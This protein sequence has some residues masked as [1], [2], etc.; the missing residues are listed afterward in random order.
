MNF[1]NQAICH[2]EEFAGNALQA[3]NIKVVTMNGIAHTCRFATGRFF[4]DKSSIIKSWFLLLKVFVESWLKLNW[5]LWK[6]SYES[7]AREPGK[8]MERSL[9]PE[10]FTRWIAAIT[11]KL[12]SLT[13]CIFYKEDEKDAGSSLED[14]IGDC[15]QY[16]GIWNPELQPNRLLCIVPKMIATSSGE[17][18]KLKEGSFCVNGANLFNSLRKTLKNLEDVDLA[19][20]K[21][22][23]IS[24][25]FY[26]KLQANPIALGTVLVVELHQTAYYTWFL[27]VNLDYNL[28]MDM[29]NPI[30][31]RLYKNLSN[32]GAGHMACKPLNVSW[33]GF[34]ERRQMSRRLNHASRRPEHLLGAP[35]AEEHL[36][37]STEHLATSTN[38]QDNGRRASIIN[39]GRRTLMREHLWAPLI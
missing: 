28:F 2:S 32:P 15:S 5:Y 16:W 14:S 11:G 35:A 30:K 21:W 23:V 6:W 12:T 18:H 8:S 17:V 31:S 3:F 24:T 7:N 29:F 9:L 10:T 34:S 4:T 25:N 22:K 36:A 1:K 39:N 33:R 19:F 13:S 26:R 27:H 37:T 38:S 20:F